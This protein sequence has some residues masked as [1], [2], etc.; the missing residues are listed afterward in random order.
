METFVVTMQD[1]T[2]LEELERL[3]AE[4]LATVSHELR[5]RLATVRGSVNRRVGLAEDS[6]QSSRVDER[7]PAGG[8]E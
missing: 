7:H 3:R 4:F 5:T 1:M 8:M 2:Q 6:R